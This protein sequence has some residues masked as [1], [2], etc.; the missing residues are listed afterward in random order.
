MDIQRYINQKEI[1][2][3]LL[4]KFIDNKGDSDQDFNNLNKEIKTQNIQKE[5]TEFKAL[6]SILKIYQIII[7]DLWRSLTKH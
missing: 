4:I 6:L 5:R 1:I 3:D 2:Y 7:I